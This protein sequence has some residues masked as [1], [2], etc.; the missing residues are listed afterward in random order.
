MN[1]DYGE[2]PWG[3]R[4]AVWVLAVVLFAA[5]PVFA[6]LPTATILGSVK[7]PSGALVAGASVTVQNV[8]TGT[9]RSISTDES[10]A[11]RLVALPVGHY[12][13]KVEAPGFK[14]TTRK[15]FV[16]DVGEEAVLNFA[17]EVGSTSETVLVAAEAPLVNT[18]TASLGGLVNEAKLAELPLNGRNYLDLVLLSP[19]ISQD[20]VIVHLGGGGEGTTYSSTGAPSSRTTSC[21]TEHPHRMFLA[22]MAPRPSALRWASTASANTGSSPTRS[23]PSMA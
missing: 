8:D 18:T 9:S 5:V 4:I 23:A 16:L 15:G 14:P 10:G 21:W 11:Y 3:C 19:G 17:L 7:D 13:L 22:T 6:Q 20:T 2:I 1:G 12:D